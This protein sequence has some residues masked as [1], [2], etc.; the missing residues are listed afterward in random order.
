MPPKPKLSYGLIYTRTMLVMARKK[1]GIIY[2]S[3]KDV[4]GVGVYI[5]C[6]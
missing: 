5:R 6:T 3:E 4:L 1:M 2:E